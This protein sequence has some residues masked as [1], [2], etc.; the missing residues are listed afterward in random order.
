[1]SPV[2]RFTVSLDTELLAAFDGNIAARGYVNR[3]EAIRDLIRDALTTTMPAV[4][5]GNV[6]AVITFVC[7]LRSAA[8][9]SRVRKIMLDTP[10]LSPSCSQVPIDE[11][12]DLWIVTIRGPSNATQAFA[13]N[14]RAVRGISEATFISRGVDGLLPAE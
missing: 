11:S 6:V 9:P 5:R 8:A 2:D 4:E 3:S 13:N 1:M 12:R 7:D 14:I 10:V